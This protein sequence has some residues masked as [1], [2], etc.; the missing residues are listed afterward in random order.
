M[1]PDLFTCEEGRAY[2]QQ[3]PYPAW[4]PAYPADSEGNPIEQ[5]YNTANNPCVDHGP[6]NGAALAQVP[7][8]LIVTLDPDDHGPAIRGEPEIDGNL[9]PLAAPVR[10]VTVCTDFAGSSARQEFQR[11]LYENTW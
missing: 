4:S 7:E 3:C 5:P 8:Q 10:D 9:P 1:R 2:V 11:L 6:T